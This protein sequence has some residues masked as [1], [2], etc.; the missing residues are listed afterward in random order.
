MHPAA[1]MTGRAMSADLARWRRRS[2]RVLAA[3]IV[4]PAAIAGLLLVVIVQVG[5]RTY[6]AATHPPAEAKTEIRLITPRFYGQSTDGRS[7]MITAR[8]AIR[9]DNDLRRIILDEPAL[10]LD[11]GSPTPTRM[12][13]K[14]GVYRQDDFSLNLK[15]DV[16]L[17]DGAG[18]RFASEQSLVD[19]R[20]GDVTGDTVMSGE[21]PTGQVQSSAYSVYDKGDRIVFRGGVRARLERQ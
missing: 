21:G 4:L 16:R 11:L 17:D 12:T 2:R 3:R 7:F 8:S 20:T 19:T 14:N 6:M 18:Y 5:W 10:T 1:A 9:D 15:N 13:A